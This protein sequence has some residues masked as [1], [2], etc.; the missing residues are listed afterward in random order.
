MLTQSNEVVKFAGQPRHIT[1]SLIVVVNANVQKLEGQPEEKHFGLAVYPCSHLAGP[2]FCLS[3]EE[4]HS[5]KIGGELCVGALASDK[6][7]VRIWNM[8]EVPNWQAF[9]RAER[10]SAWD[11]EKATYTRTF[12]NEILSFA[13]NETGSLLAIITHVKNVRRL[14]VISTATNKVVSSNDDMPL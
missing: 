1:Q 10:A 6:L 5:V 9:M 8:A 2:P 4:P 3:Q 13:I 12:D 14:Y 11:L 7:T